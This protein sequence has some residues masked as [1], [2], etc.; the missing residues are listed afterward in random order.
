MKDRIQKVASIVS[1]I[2]YETE[3]CS[4]ELLQ[5]GFNKKCTNN[6]QECWEIAITEYLNVK[7]EKS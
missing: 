1:E 4:T 3:H 7:E 6:C 2:A 5:S